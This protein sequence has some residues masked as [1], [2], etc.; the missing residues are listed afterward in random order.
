M[1]LEEEGKDSV[2]HLCS[3][4]GFPWSL[5]EAP[6]SSACQGGERERRKEGLGMNGTDKSYDPLS[7]TNDRMKIICSACLADSH[8]DL[9]QDV[10]TSES[11]QEVRESLYIPTCFTR[12]T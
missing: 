5:E 8:Q 6:T 3:L 10:S 1:V 2:L 4:I 11:G 7:L 12:E 9:G